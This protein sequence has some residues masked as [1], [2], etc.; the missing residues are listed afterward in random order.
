[1]YAGAS[2]K[3]DGDIHEEA[4]AMLLSLGGNVERWRRATRL[5]LTRTAAAIEHWPANARPQGTRTTIEDEAYSNPLTWPLLI[6]AIELCHAVF[7]ILA[8]L[9]RDVDKVAFGDREQVD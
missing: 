2:L 4:S 6:R 3:G 8:G 5:A 1:M 9:Q 7:E